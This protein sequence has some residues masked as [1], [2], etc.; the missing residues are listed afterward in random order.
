[1]K[2]G[3]ILLGPQMARLIF[4]ICRYFELISIDGF[5]LFF[6]VICGQLLYGIHAKVII[7]QDPAMFEGTVRNNLDPW[8]NTLMIKFG[9]WVGIKRL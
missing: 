7:P 8:K 2:I 5:V 3:Q 4:K 6:S 1:M 9:R